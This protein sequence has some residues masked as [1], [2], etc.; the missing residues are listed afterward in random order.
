MLRRQ[1]RPIERDSYRTVQENSAKLMGWKRSYLSLPH[2]PLPAKKKTFEDFFN[3]YPALLLQN[4]RY[5]FRDRQQFLPFS[6]AQ[7]IEIKKKN[8]VFDKKLTYIYVDG[9]CYSL[10][11]VQR[12]LDEA[13]KKK[14]AAFMCMQSLDI[15]PDATRKM[16]IEWLDKRIGPL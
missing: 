5:A 3:T 10:E 2:A 4:I 6:L 1:H 16:M 14:N 8:T 7:N 15:T 12:R 11:K 9:S 13:D